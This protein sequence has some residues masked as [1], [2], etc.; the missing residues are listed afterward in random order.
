MAS[1]NPGTLVLQQ[2]G[3]HPKK[4]A[5]GFETRWCSAHDF[6][7]RH[8]YSDHPRAVPLNRWHLGHVLHQEHPHHDLAPLFEVVP[9][10]AKAW[11]KRLLQKR[12]A[13]E[14]P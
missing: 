8:Q 11:Q 2:E 13:E 12:S 6:V 9:Q 3:N 10:E 14:I 1:Q 4:D 7:I 5:L